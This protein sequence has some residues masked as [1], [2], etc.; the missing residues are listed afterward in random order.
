MVKESTEELT[1]K[2]L[3]TSFHSRQAF[4]K[5][6]IAWVCSLLRAQSCWLVLVVYHLWSSFSVKVRVIRFWQPYLLSWIFINI[7]LR[8]AQLMMT[9]MTTVFART[10]MWPNTPPRLQLPSL[11]LV[12]PCLVYKQAIRLASLLCNDISLGVVISLAFLTDVAKTN[13]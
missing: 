4:T 10:D 2:H 13:G 5:R 8:L 3:S 11:R 6:T 1:V 7:G 9:T 12:K